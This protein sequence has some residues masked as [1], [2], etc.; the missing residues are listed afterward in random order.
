M[1][2]QYIFAIQDFFSVISLIYSTL[3]NSLVSPCNFSTDL[4]HKF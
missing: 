1:L 2:N 4:I 3:T